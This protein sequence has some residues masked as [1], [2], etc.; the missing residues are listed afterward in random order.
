MVSVGNHESE[1]HSPACLGSKE[2][3]N[4]LRNFSAYNARWNMPAASS[5]GVEA[6]WYSWNQGPVHFISINTETDWPGATEEKVGDSGD[7]SL[8]AGSFGRDGEFVVSE[9]MH[10]PDQPTQCARRH[11]AGGGYLTSVQQRC[12]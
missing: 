12:P 2:R 4:S 6:M 9:S 3:S 11:S 1:C 10:A 5:K 8:P 7:K